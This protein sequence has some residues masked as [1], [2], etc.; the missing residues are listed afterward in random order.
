MKPP[1]IRHITHAVTVD[2]PR[3]KYGS[4]RSTGHT[5]EKNARAQYAHAKR[6][7]DDG[8]RLEAEGINH[9][10]RWAHETRA[11]A[12]GL[13]EWSQGGGRWVLIESYGDD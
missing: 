3:S 12:C 7:V 13:W 9:W 2:R 8:K 6:L 4:Q 10:N 1:K 5:S 11:T